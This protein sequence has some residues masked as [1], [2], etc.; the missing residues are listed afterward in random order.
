MA[1]DKVQRFQKGCIVSEYTTG[2]EALQIERD[3]LSAMEYDDTLP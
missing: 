1:I 2:V 3:R